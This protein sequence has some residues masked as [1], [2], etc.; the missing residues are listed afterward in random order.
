MWAV[1]SYVALNIHMVGRQREYDVLQTP[2]LTLFWIQLG[3][4]IS[5]PLR[6]VDPFCHAKDSLYILCIEKKDHDFKQAF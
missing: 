4:C 6:V 2:V 1:L 5:S 3:I